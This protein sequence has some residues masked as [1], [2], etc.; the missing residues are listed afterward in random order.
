MFIQLEGVEQIIEFWPLIKQALKE[1]PPLIN[2]KTGKYG[3][4]YEELLTG[5]YTVFVLLDDDEQIKGIVITG[6]LYDIMS[7]NKNLLLYLLYSVSQ[8]TKKDFARIVVGVKTYAKTLACEQ[9]VGYVKDDNIKHLL[10]RLNCNLDYTFFT[11]K[12]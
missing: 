3:R 9:I 7:G 6:V 5:A 10:E 1:G 11:Y 12:L 8:L 4:M 2:E